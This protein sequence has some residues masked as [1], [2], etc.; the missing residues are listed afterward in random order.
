MGCVLI[1]HLFRTHP[2]LSGL[3]GQAR[4][5]FTQKASEGLTTINLLRKRSPWKAQG[6]E[7]S[8]SF[9]LCGQR[10]VRTGR[11]EG[12]HFLRTKNQEFAV[13]DTAIETSVGT[14][15]EAF[16]GFFSDFGSG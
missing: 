9:Q 2:A 1:T 11:R 7:K 13:L 3:S 6:S 5:R 8:Q 4:D 16:T 12:P 15:S 14:G 10:P